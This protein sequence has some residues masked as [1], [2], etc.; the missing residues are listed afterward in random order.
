MRKIA[1]ILCL[2]PIWVPA[3]EK[4]SINRDAIAPMPAIKSIDINKIKNSKNESTIRPVVQQGFTYMQQGWVGG[5]NG[6]PKIRTAYQAYFSPSGKYILTYGADNIVRL[7]SV[8]GLL[9]STFPMSINSKN[10][11]IYDFDNDERNICLV[12]IPSYGDKIFY[13]CSLEGNLLKTF[14][15]PM[16]TTINWIMLNDNTDKVVVSGMFEKDK[17]SARVSAT[18]EYMIDRN[19]WQNWNPTV[20]SKVIKNKNQKRQ[21]K[22]QNYSG[23]FDFKKF[24]RDDY[25]RW[26][27]GNFPGEVVVKSPVNDYV[28]IIGN[29]DNVPIKLF[30]PDGTFLKSIG[31]YTPTLL[32]FD[33]SQDGNIIVG[34]YSDLKIRVWDRFGFLVRTFPVSTNHI[35]ITLNTITGKQKFETY[36]IDGY[37]SDQVSDLIIKKVRLLKISPDGQ[38]IGVF[39][40]GLNSIYDLKGNLKLVLKTNIESFA[41]T[42]D[43]KYIMVSGNNAKEVNFYDLKGNCV[44]TLKPN[45]GDGDPSLYINFN[46]EQNLFAV[47]NNR[48][49]KSFIIDEKGSVKEKNN[50]VLEKYRIN[51]S[52]IV[53]YSKDQKEALFTVYEGL[54]IIDLEKS[55]TKTVG[56]RNVNQ[57]VFYPDRKYILVHTKENKLLLVDR[58]GQIVKEYGGIPARVDIMDFSPDGE[59]FVLQ[60]N[61][62]A[63]RIYNTETGHYT[64]SAA[65][66]NEWIAC[67][68]EGY[69]D[70][71]K[72]GGSL[73]AI[74]KGGYIYPCDQFAINYNRPDTMMISRVNS[75]QELVKHYKNQF[76]KRLKKTGIS[77]LKDGNKSQ[78]PEIEIVSFDQKD[79]SYTINLHVQ[80]SI[81]AVAKYNIF[82]NDV[83][84]Y[85]STGKPFG[86][87]SGEITETFELSKGTNKI[88]VTCF[89]DK[90]YESLRDVTYAEYNASVKTDLYMLAFGVSKY[91]NASLNLQFAD[92][93]ALD[94]EKAFLNMKGKGFENVYTKVLTNEQVTPDA[95]KASKDFVKNAKPDD[96]FI[97]FIAGHGMHDKDAEATYYYLTSNADINNL[98]AT[99]AD[100]ETIEGLLQGI[101]PRNKLFLMDAC[102]SGEIDEETYE[103][104]T[105]SKT[106]SGL[107]M[108]SRGFK[109]T[110]APSTVNAQPS[111][112]RTYLYQKDRYIYNDLV[113]RSGAI[114]FSSSKGGELS[115]E[116]SDIENGLFT[117]YIIK[118]IT[119]TDAD[120]DNN[121]IVT[122]DEMRGYVAE[123]VANA[124]SN[125]Q[126]PTVDRDNIY[127]NFGIGYNLTNNSSSL[128]FQMVD[129]KGGTFKLYVNNQ[130]V[131]LGD[132]KIGVYEV[133]Q[134]QWKEVM[135][136]NPSKFPDCDNCPVEN[137]TW[138][139]VQQ[140][141]EKLNAK[142]GLKYR[143]P[144]LAE[145]ELAA[146]GGALNSK[147]L[148][149]EYGFLKHIGTVSEVHSWNYKN[150]KGRPQPTGLKIPNPIGVYDIFGNVSEYTSTWSDPAKCNS[151]IVV[152]GGGVDWYVSNFEQ[153]Y[154]KPNKAQT[155][156][157]SL[158]NGTEVIGFRLA[159]DVE[160]QVK[161]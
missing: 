44:K 72:D 91:S 92:K 135:G 56:I 16:S 86:K 141:I 81:N 55:T 146:R 79:K 18:M 116:R 40:G 14:T 63:L 154:V 43:S 17:Y 113:R 149:N 31:T 159:L 24:I 15:V 105:G 47:S 36:E 156:Y 2:L 75:D 118:A 115:Y 70:G 98:K 122:T 62:G 125:F 27:E 136:N 121:G 4:F 28:L 114:V 60:G 45:L 128:T 138:N 102:E 20:D 99:A 51:V 112:K 29:K 144:T 3:Q 93:D 9:Y 104:L 42:P 35:V 34:L 117:E 108:A 48:Q 52:D 134:A 50:I 101:P 69:F 89:N 67:T 129:V 10:K 157:K 84:L 96:T 11:A 6:G 133:T 54:T 33:I 12:E 25:S 85:G 73:I 103:T 140:F 150:S 161:K 107:G 127:I 8:K 143:L 77:N 76:V 95:I 26:G 5:E 64:I 22:W 23:N 124:S 145:W 53:N 132:Y 71:S 109:A 49:V 111:T 65:R 13:I 38:L 68:D 87:K 83:P 130:K 57:A 61:E 152:V 148:K 39:G 153:E 80:D 158:M 147:E 120:K 1:L 32:G 119:S 100:F 46:N 151:C 59:Y 94:L 160:S 142:T 123:E 82:V 58:T 97:L 74:A 7:Y 90:G 155:D 137:V 66:G 30:R 106:L 131:T 21:N 37:L 78:V 110:S 126:H 88:E 41:F 139:E 19:T